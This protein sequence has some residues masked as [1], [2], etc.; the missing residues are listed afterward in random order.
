MTF[1]I[2]EFWVV[3]GMVA[4]IAITIGSVR[5]ADWLRARRAKGERGG[6]PERRA[7]TR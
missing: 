5:F 3:V 1:N 6:R 4:T 2:G 7:A